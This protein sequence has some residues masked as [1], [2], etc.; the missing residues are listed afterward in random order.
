MTT[1]TFIHSG[2]ASDPNNWSEGTFQI[3]LTLVFSN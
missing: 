2:L 1:D 3:L